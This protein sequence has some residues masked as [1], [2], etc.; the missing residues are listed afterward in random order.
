MSELY[1]AMISRLLFFFLSET[2]RKDLNFVKIQN[3]IHLF[4]TQIFLLI[5]VRLQ[6]KK[7]GG[8]EVDREKL[9]E[10]KKL[11]LVSYLILCLKTLLKNCLSKL[12][13]HKA[14]C[15]CIGWACVIL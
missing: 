8:Q 3:I 4:I 11:L 13:L 2:L 12:P 15:R 9:Y 14:I 1:Q 5:F 10:N 7:R 6:C